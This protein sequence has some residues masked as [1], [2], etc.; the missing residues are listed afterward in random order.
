M[1]LLGAA[2]KGILRGMVFWL[3]ASSTARGLSPHGAGGSR[4]MATS[5]LPWR[6]VTSPMLLRQSADSCRH[7]RGYWPTLACPQRRMTRAVALA[8]Q[9]SKDSVP[10]PS[11]DRNTRAVSLPSISVHV[12]FWK[13]QTARG[14]RERDATLALEVGYGI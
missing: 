3:R 8:R 2:A 9:D 6:R 10:K 14:P 4:N 7:P 11:R 12:R 1:L 13:G 5:I